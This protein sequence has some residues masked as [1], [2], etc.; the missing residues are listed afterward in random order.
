MA[1]KEENERRVYVLPVE[2]LERVR[3]YQSANGIGSEVEA[4]RRLLDAALQM[5]DT[6]RDVLKILKSRYAAEKDLRVLARDILAGHALIRSV[7]Y[8]D[9]AVYFFFSNGEGGKIDSGGATYVGDAREHE[10][11]HDWP[12]PPKTTARA[13]ARGGS[14]PTWDAPKGGDFDDEIPF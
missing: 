14:G 7:H 4:V 9:D 12:P 13:A 5:R 6:V 10:V 11:W 2:Q 3:A 1:E 8:D